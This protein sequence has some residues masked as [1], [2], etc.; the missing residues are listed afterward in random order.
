MTKI[1]ITDRL[2]GSLSETYFKEYCD[3]Q[4]WAYVSLEQINENKIKDNVIK[5]KKGFHRFFIQLPDEIIKEVERISNPSNSSILNPTYVYDFLLCK[6]GQTVKDSNII[7][8]KNFEDVRWAEV[9]T[10]YSKLTARQISTQKKI[11]IPLY[12]YR[13]PNSKVG[14]DKVEIFDDLVD[15]EFLSYES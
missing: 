5:F 13:V 11:T 14:S 1:D 7:K 3:Q 6:V 2:S 15:S 4:G 12:R 9:K 10:G 8:K